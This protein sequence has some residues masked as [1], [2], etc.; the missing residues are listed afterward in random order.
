MG[1]ESKKKQRRRDDDGVAS[2][3]IPP[4]RAN[5]IFDD[6]AYNEFLKTRCSRDED[7]AQSVDAAVNTLDDDD[8]GRGVGGGGIERSADDNAFLMAIKR[9]SIQKILSDGSI[10]ENTTSSS[11]SSNIIQQT[12]AATVALADDEF[13][14]AMRGSLFSRKTTKFG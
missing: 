8:E 2:S 4:H 5:N 14:A 9:A 13:L 3:S 6:N 11:S 12:N 7:E 10:I 1:E